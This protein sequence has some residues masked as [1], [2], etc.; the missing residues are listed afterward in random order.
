MREEQVSE[1]ESF[2]TRPVNEKKKV[3]SDLKRYFPH[4]TTC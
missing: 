2:E 4:V 1:E 3:K